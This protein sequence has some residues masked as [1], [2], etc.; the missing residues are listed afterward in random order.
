MSELDPPACLRPQA[1]SREDHIFDTYATVAGMDHGG[2]CIFVLAVL[3][4]H[5]NEAGESWPTIPRIMQRSG[6]RLGREKILNRLD[7]LRRAGL[8]MEVGA[9]GKA[10]KWLVTCL[11]PEQRQA[12]S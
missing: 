3:I 8:I 11:A 9:V 4:D 6:G 1:M 2:E 10:R 7:Q 12:A 5:A